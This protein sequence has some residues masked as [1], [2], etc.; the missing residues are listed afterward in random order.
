M[1][2]PAEK[3]T[4]SKES[5][6]IAKGLAIL[7]ML[8]Y[9]LFYSKPDNLDMGVIFSPIPENVF[10]TMARFGNI[11]VAVFVMITAYGL[12]AKLFEKEN[13][14]LMEACGN[15]FK[16]AGKLLFH[17]AFMFVCVNLLWFHWFDYA[18]TFGKGKQGVLAF[19]LDGL[20]LSHLFN[21]PTINMTWW[22]M[23]LAYTLVFLVP[24]LAFA[25]K[26]TG[27]SFLGI[28]LLTPYILPLGEDVSRY[29]FVIA[30]GIAAAY[31]N[32]FEK[33]L[34]SKMHFALRWL[35]EIALIVLSVF[36]RDNE[37]VKTNLIAPAD[38]LIAFVIILFAVD[39]IGFIPVIR[40]VAAFLGKHS[41]NIFFVHTFFYLILYR[42]YVYY[43]GYAPLTFLILLGLSLAL[44]LA[45]EGLKYL[46]LKAFSA[47]RKASK[48]EK[49]N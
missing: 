17:F 7:L 21:S 42:K 24:L 37:F 46:F 4:F 44:S 40:T 34:N 41:M 16:R 20:G 14:T 26:K 28:A 43:F 33:I 9:H 27:Y 25:M 38:A 1:T 15:S 19:F 18:V 47:I 10:L 23:S 36:I 29:F 13:P 32:W 22:Y 11:C 5:S 35:I 2:K 49:S 31:G 3:R 8:F 48:K 39:C 45:I 6:K 12:S 30:I